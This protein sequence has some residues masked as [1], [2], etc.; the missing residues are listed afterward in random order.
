MQHSLL[1][2]HDPGLGPV[3]QLQELVL[4]HA[5]KG[6]AAR[7]CGSEGCEPVACFPKAMKPLALSN[8]ARKEALA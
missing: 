8:A 6:F 2:S 7:N 4:F 5:G 3:A 1:P